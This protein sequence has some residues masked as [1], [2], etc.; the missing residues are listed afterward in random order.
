[1]AQ[2]IVCMSVKKLFATIAGLLFSFRTFWEHYF[3]DT[4]DLSGENVL[5]DYSLPVIA[6]AQLLKFPAVGQPRRAMM[7]AIVSFLINIV[8]LFLIAGGLT[9]FVDTERCGC[10]EE[11][12]AALAGFALTPVWFM[13]PLYCIDG[14]SWLAAIVSIA[15]AS[16]IFRSGVVLLVDRY[17]EPLRAGRV[18]RNVTLFFVAICVVQFLV[19]RGVFHVFDSFVL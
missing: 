2:E 19:E 9:C 5:N 4:S 11:R 14:W 1:M 18:L 3:E 16:L 17:L 7:I 15:Y 8:I 12:V 6:M 13:G 10:P